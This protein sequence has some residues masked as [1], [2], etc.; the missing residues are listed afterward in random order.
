V[1][2]GKRILAFAA[3]ALV[4]LGTAYS[5]LLG[6]LWRIEASHTDA[7][8]AHLKA[9]LSDEKH[10]AAGLEADV[11]DLTSKVEGNVSTIDTLAND[12]A[13][14]Q[15]DLVLYG[16]AALSLGECARERATFTGELK[17][18]G[19][20]YLWSLQAVQA[21]MDKYCDEIHAS[22]VDMVNGNA[23]S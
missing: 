20:Y 23:A 7:T 9:T 8:T 6:T 15:D 1:T 11:A 18:R 5:L 14:A 2:Q 3:I 10:T 13:Q 12:R 16:S 19:D 17:H 21:D 4:G 22:Y